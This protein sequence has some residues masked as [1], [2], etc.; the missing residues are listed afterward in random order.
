MRVCWACGH[1]PDP[2]D[3]A[4]LRKLQW[5]LTLLWAAITLP[6]CALLYVGRDHPLISIFAF[7]WLT[8]VSHYANMATHWGAYQGARA[9]VAAQANVQVSKD[10]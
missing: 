2:D 4:R 7:I 8:F 1:T 3:A 6:V 10:E 5:R 9:E